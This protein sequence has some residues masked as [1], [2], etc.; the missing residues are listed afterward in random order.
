MGNNQNIDILALMEEYPESFETKVKDALARTDIGD[1]QGVYLHIP[2]GGGGLIAGVS[3]VLKELMPQ[4][5]ITAVESEQA[6]SL[7]VSLD[8][9]EK[10]KV[11]VPARYEDGSKLAGGTAVSE[12]GEIPLQILKQLN[13]NA[14][15]IDKQQM[16]WGSAKMNFAMEMRSEMPTGA[17]LASSLNQKLPSKY[18]VL[19]VTGENLDPEVEQQL[20]DKVRNGELKIGDNR[21]T[22]DAKEVFP[23]SRDLLQY[24][25]L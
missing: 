17:A 2:V 9:G 20:R 5:K 13:I 24:Q 21:E 15:T 3:I 7:T 11:D 1:G 14:T 4:C 25:S 12:V 8:A 19:L 23:R 10:R 6:N 22:N 18:E 16:Q